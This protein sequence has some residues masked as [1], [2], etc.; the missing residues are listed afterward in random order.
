MRLLFV[1]DGRSPIALNWIDYFME[2]GHQVHLVSTY[3]CDPDPRLVSYHLIPVAFSR[4]AGG[5]RAPQG[6][7]RGTAAVRVRTLIRQWLGPLTLPNAVPALRLVIDKLQPELVHAMRIPYEGMLAALANPRS[8]LLVSIWG[9]DFTLHALSN[10]VLGRYTRLTLQRADALHADC[11]R[12]IR[13]ANAWEFNE[14]SPSV[15]LPGAGGVQRDIFYPPLE[16]TQAEQNPLV[17]N[18]RGI[19]AY[20]RNDTFF[21]AVPIILESKPNV[22]FVCPVMLGEPEAHRWVE[23][24]E[25]FESVE[26]LPRQTRLQ[27]AELFRRSLVAVSPSTHDGTP[28]TL[29]EAMACGCYP[30]AGDLE[31]LREWIETGVNGSLVDPSDPHALAKAVLSVL[32]DTKLRGNASAYNQRLIERRAEY[33]G[34]MRRAE[35]FYRSLI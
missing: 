10:P 1:A 17:I 13:L 27:M 6:R 29:L 12:D 7:L 25:L 4:L 33:Q 26:L 19:R 18:P 2:A 35:Q 20:V 14:N 23:H 9:N 11:Q 3:P 8:P 30:V 24:L 5:G 21:K 32:Q 31:S 28:N 15:V 16:G 34:V 22:H